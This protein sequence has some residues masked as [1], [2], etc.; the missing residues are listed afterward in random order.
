MKQKQIT[1]KRGF[2]TIRYLFRKGLG[3]AC[4]LLLYYYCINPF[5]VS[6]VRCLVSAPSPTAK[7]IR[8]KQSDME[9]SRPNDSSKTVRWVQGRL[10]R[11]CDASFVE[12]SVFGTVCTKRRC[13]CF[14]RI[15]KS[16]AIC[17]IGTLSGGR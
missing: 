15:W 10:V 1:R 14:Q 3:R 7:Q 2:Q 9:A 13:K 17:L 11:Y 8:L 16:L 4:V 12:H 6:H 5:H